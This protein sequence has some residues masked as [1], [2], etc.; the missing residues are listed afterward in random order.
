M[1]SYGS[2]NDKM[3]YQVS[4]TLL[5]IMADLYNL[6]TWIVYICAVVSQ[7]SSLWAPITNARGV[8][9]IVA[10]NGHDETS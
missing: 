7:S 10:G 4:R 2:L 9:D 8:I 5:S 1:V 3:S 6:I